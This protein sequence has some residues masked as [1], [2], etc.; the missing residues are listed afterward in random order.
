MKVKRL[1]AD[2]HSP[3]ESLG[4]LSFDIPMQDRLETGK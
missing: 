3:K 4:Q 2:G 1:L